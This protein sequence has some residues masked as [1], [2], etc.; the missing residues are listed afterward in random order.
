MDAIAA[1][2]QDLLT[3][4]TTALAD[5]RFGDVDAKTLARAAADVESAADVVA[6][7]QA[8][9][10]SAREVL[11]ERQEALLQQAQRAVAYAR[12]Y[13]ESDDALTERLAAIALPRPA[14]R[15]RA[16]GEALVLSPDP[17]PAA[18]PR[19]RPRKVR[20]EEPVTA[21]EPRELALT[22]AE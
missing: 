6:A 22:G 17:E 7:A 10:D 19:G 9:L 18:R 20:P 3:L 4:F 1:P 2:I 14:R 13:A 5:V 21:G 16:S 15:A 12:V 11:Q 8:A